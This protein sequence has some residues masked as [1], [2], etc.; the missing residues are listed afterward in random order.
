MHN[1][2]TPLRNGKQNL[3]SALIV[4]EGLQL[5]LSETCW[6]LLC[7]DCLTCIQGISKKKL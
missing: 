5:F 1:L 2:C 7:S 3:R 6:G 4:T